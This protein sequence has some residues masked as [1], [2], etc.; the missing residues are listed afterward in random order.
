MTDFN[1]TLE[2][3]RARFLARAA[4][5]L[6]RL[7]G[8]QQGTV[9]AKPELLALVHHMAGNA[10]MFGFQNISVLASDVELQLDNDADATP[11]LEALV[12]LLQETVEPKE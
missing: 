8:H 1:T 5:D 3:F 10:G 9:L 6:S 7:R 4:H 12:A 11:T 2:K